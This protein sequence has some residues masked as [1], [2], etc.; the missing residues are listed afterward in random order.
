MEGSGF[1]IEFC[2]LGRCATFSLLHSLLAKKVKLSPQ[3]KSSNLG[4]AVRSSRIRGAFPTMVYVGLEAV[5]C[6]C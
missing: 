2:S 6:F 1:E 4:R 5:C 3:M